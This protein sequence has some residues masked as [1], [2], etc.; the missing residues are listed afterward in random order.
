MNTVA[1][2]QEWIVLEGN[3]TTLNSLLVASRMIIKKTTGVTPADV[4]GNAEA[5]ELYKLVQK[6]IVADNFENRLGSNNSQLLI[7]YCSQL[8]S[9]KLVGE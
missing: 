3:E 6:M 1:E 8:Q 2:L 4:T 9:Y 5:T 7:G